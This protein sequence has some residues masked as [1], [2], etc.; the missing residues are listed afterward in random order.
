MTAKL[1]LSGFTLVEL[2]ITLAVAGVL[3]TVAVPS[4]RLLFAHS[5][6]ASLTTTLLAD[7]RFARS[8]ALTRGLRVS[9]CRSADGARC[10]DQGGWH[11]GWLV[12]ANPD[13]DDQR[14]KH[15][16]LL[17]VHR[18]TQSGVRLIGNRYV[19]SHVD[20]DSQGFAQGTAGTITACAGAGIVAAIVIP[21]SGAVH[22]DKGD[23]DAC[24]Q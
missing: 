3:L 8:E 17:R 6:N 9:L 16:P 24:A 7:L 14:E 5:H 2:L 13:G 23:S 10:S 22:S 4:Y 21:F 12:F 11:Q 20:F 18:A 1:G 19:S 15:E